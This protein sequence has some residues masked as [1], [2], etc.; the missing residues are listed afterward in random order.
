MANN[1][2]KAEPTA[3]TFAVDN[4]NRNSYVAAPTSNAPWRV[5]TFNHIPWKGLLALLV[6][7]AGIVASIGILIASNRDAVSRWSVSPTVYIAIA[8]AVTNVLLSYSLRKA[9]DVAWWKK[10][11][12]DGTSIADLHRQ[13]DF[14]SSVGKALLAGRHV[15]MIA[16]ACILCAIAPINGPLLQRASTVTTGLSEKNVEVSLDMAQQLPD[17]YT[18]F[19]SGRQRVVSLLTTNFTAVANAAQMGTPINFTSQGCKGDCY[20]RIR[21]AG[22][23]VNCTPSTSPFDL[24]PQVSK[25]GSLDTSSQSV[26]NGTRAFGSSIVW[27]N[28]SPS[29]LQLGVQYK[30]KDSCTGDLQIRNCTLQASVVEYPVHIDGNT[31]TISLQSGT[32]MFDDKIISQTEYPRQGAIGAVTLGGMAKALQDA[33]GS[34]ANLRFAGAVGYELLTTGATANRYAIVDDNGANANNCSLSFTDPTED[35]LAA[36]RDMMFRTAVAAS[37]STSTQKVL[38]Q[39]SHQQ[40]IY[41][42]HYLY[43]GLATLFSAIAIIAIFPSFLGWTAVG[44]KTSMSPIETA[45][46]FRA[47]M[48][49]GC[50]PNLEGSEIVKAV[51]DRGVKYGAVQG[52]EGGAEWLGMNMPHLVRRPGGGERFVG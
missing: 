50:D 13:W 5:G 51:G 7:I 46:A 20:T 6:S 29:V 39:E 16:I 35:I 32:Q 11:T 19:I 18:G 23:A 31:S 33:Y 14:G 22:F 1:H 44:R 48:L 47:P 41:V 24:N 40:P 10:A 37:N 9:L 12:Q 36:V 15:N 25:G 49:M 4:S 3:E 30:D 21:G 27:D 45:K 43:L 2:L 34:T 42:S 38:A 8:S 17:G 52:S 26:A 28:G